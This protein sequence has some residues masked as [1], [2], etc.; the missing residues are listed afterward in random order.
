MTGALALP[1]AA[2]ADDASVFA[3]WGSHTPELKAANEAY[4]DAARDYERGGRPTRA[5]HEALISANDQINSAETAIRAEV[6]AQEPSTARG[7][8]AKRLTLQLIDIGLVAN[9]YENNGYR[10]YL[11]HH[12]AVARRWMRRSDREA[13]R[14]VRVWK[15]TKR[16]WLRAGFKYDQS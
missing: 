11:D 8:K 3:A 12:P 14:Y 15:Q 7:A 16:A 2:N 10:A 1:A 9:N 13:R 5:E 4:A 6:A